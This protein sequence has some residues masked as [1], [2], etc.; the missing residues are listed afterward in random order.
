MP[1]TAM[2]VSRKALSGKRQKT[3]EKKVKK[4]YRCQAPTFPYILYSQGCGM[5]GT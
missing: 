1:L 5:R 4:E 2:P 3:K